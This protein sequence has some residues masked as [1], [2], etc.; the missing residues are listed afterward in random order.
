MDYV[1][2]IYDVFLGAGEAQLTEDRRVWSRDVAR[3]C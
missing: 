3:S 1:V 2:E